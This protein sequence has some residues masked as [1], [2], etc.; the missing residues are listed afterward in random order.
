MSPARLVPL[1][2]RRDLAP[3]SSD[4][5]AAR[6]SGQIKPTSIEDIIAWKH[7]A[8]PLDVVWATAAEGRPGDETGRDL[9]PRRSLRRVGLAKMT[10][11]ASAFQSD[12]QTRWALELDALA[13]ILPI[14]RRDRLAELL[15]H[16]DV[17]T[18]KHPAREGMGKNTLRALTSDRLP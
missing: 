5:I 17:E 12:P 10:G 1:E 16:D 2:P 7:D 14:D 13:A 15:T 9:R 11:I 4:M 18:L 6:D 3:L 8:Q